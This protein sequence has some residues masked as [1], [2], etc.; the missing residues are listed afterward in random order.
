MR[1]FVRTLFL[2]ALTAGATAGAQ[3][4]EQSLAAYNRKDYATALAGF[5]KLADQ[6]VAAA[7]YGMGVMYA[8]GRG[9]AKDETEAVRWYR[10]A[11]DQDVA[12][13]QL[14]LGLAYELGR[15]V[16]KDATEAVR[17]YRKSADQGLRFA[18]YRLALMYD[19]GQGVARNNVEAYKW[20]VLAEAG[21]FEDAES[22]RRNLELIMTREEIAEA[23]RLASQWK[24]R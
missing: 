15:G 23:R 8:N 6:G 16:P 22:D 1:P 21:G 2:A 4:L 3:T 9:V 19:R 24:P 14:D 13:A 17:W 5:E 7:Q 20:L 12:A 11:A 10:K 18:Q